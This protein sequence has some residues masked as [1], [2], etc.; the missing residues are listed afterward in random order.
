WA[1]V[2]ET[3]KRETRMIGGGAGQA[4]M[5]LAQTLAR[6]DHPNERFLGTCLLG[7]DTTSP[8]A[9]RQAISALRIQYPE[10]NRMDRGITTRIYRIALK[11]SERPH[12]LEPCA[13]WYQEA[14]T[15]LLRHSSWHI[16]HPGLWGES[17]FPI[18]GQ[19]S[20]YMPE[21][22]AF[23]VEQAKLRAHTLNTGRLG[24][25]VDNNWSE[26][27]GFNS[28]DLDQV[29][30]AF[31]AVLPRFETLGQAH[32]QAGYAVHIARRLAKIKGREPTITAPP[33]QLRVGPL[34]N[35]FFTAL[36]VPAHLRE[37]ADVYR[38]GHYLVGATSGWNLIRQSTRDKATGNRTTTYFL[39]TFDA[40]GN[41][42]DFQRLPVEVGTG[43]VTNGDQLMT[44]DRWLGMAGIMR[45]PV[46]RK[47]DDVWLVFD[48][49]REPWPWRAHKTAST[50]GFMRGAALVGDHL[51]YAFV[52]NPS[53]P[54][55]GGPED[56]ETMGDPTF[57]VV[58]IDLVTG[59]ETL[60]ASSRR[61]PGVTP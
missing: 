16:T 13:S 53:G 9:Y 56:Y 50:R 20:G 14:F 60:L 31:A 18:T 8:A 54:N 49:S 26:A 25:C 42:T 22:R 34:R 23:M 2:Y 37:S 10:V 58:D 15:G 3:A 36:P 47:A 30:E 61:Q 55:S 32:E 46:T 52:H 44:N 6:S 19:N 4:W 38:L 11:L 43:I 33:H 21:F 51:I 27:N 29:G 39:H 5:R 7:M 35:P 45:D 48:R 17:R 12:I 28:A 40:S 41:P 24:S 59:Q 1:V 57:G